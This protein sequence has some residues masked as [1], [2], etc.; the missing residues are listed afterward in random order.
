MNDKFNQCLKDI[1]M[2][3]VSFFTMFSKKNS[4]HHVMYLLSFPENNDQLIQMLDQDP[5]IDKLTIL[6]QKQLVDEVKKYQSLGI[7][8]IQINSLGFFIKGLP[9]L[10]QAKVIIMDNYFAFIGAINFSKETTIYQIWHAAGAIKCFGWEDPKTTLRSHQDQERFQKVYNSTHYYVVGSEEMAN[11]FEKSYLQPTKKM[12]LTGVPRTDFFFNQEAKIIAENKFKQMFPEVKDKK[13]VLYAPTYR[14]VTMSTENWQKV[15]PSLS[16]DYV[17]LGK[18]HPHTLEQLSVDVLKHIQIDL[19]GLTLKELLFSVDVL[20]TDYSSIPF[21]Y[22]LAKPDGH[23]IYYTFDLE[24][25][26]QTVGIQPDFYQ[27]HHVHPVETKEI[28]EQ[29]FDQLELYKNG[30]LSEWHTANDGRATIRLIAHIK[31]ELKK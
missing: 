9:M 26:C 18:F 30:S 21:E 20:I 11:V 1:Y 22:E 16:D 28:L 10:K 14:E 8:C 15:V 31:Q 19:R 7:E 4:S 25:Y 17:V 6:Y 5:L 29:A 13:I 3:V 27:R 12:L 23:T 2:K 24:S